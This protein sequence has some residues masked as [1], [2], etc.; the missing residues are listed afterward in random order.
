ME[1]EEAS[2]FQY[3]GKEEARWLAE[4]IYQKCTQLLSS[5]TCQF[6]SP[7]TE[8]HYSFNTLPTCQDDA[9]Q[10]AYEEILH[11]MRTLST[12]SHTRATIQ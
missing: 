12:F 2:T 3:S 6:L 9:R 4:A 8:T 7:I 11:F 1:T 5:I 10:K